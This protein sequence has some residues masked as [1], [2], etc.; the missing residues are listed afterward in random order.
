MISNDLLI[1]KEN[2]EGLLSWYNV[3]SKVLKNPTPCLMKL[4]NSDVCG[5]NEC[6][7]LEQ[8]AR[9]ETDKSQTN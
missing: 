4:N 1:K 3:S 9:F 6:K 7:D 5:C 8:A 2:R